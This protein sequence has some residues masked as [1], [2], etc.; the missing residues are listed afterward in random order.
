VC[1]KEEKKYPKLCIQPG[2]LGSGMEAQFGERSRLVGKADRFA[3]TGNSLKK[4][5]RGF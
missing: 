3:M 1:S 5:P 2:V 4:E